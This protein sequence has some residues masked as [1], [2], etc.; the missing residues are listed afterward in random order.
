MVSTGSSSTVTTTVVLG[1]RK[2][3]QSED[4]LSIRLECASI[5]G[6]TYESQTECKTDTIQYASPSRS[7]A[8]PE[9]RYRCSYEGCSKAYTKPSRLAEHERVHT[10][11]VC[12]Y[13]CFLAY[14]KFLF[15]RP[16]T[17]S[18]CNKSYL[19]ETH[20]QAHTRSHLPVSARPFV[21]NE[22]DCGKRFWTSQH[23]RVHSELHR[24]E[25]PFK[26][27]IPCT[28]LFAYS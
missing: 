7:P 2:S 6:S 25:K 21:C 13:L 5:T 1:K 19:R 24:G 3:R 9:R 28:I 17:C 23:L 10:G 22:P 12:R 16:Y 4:K 27:R 26:V 20:L 11:D 8:I 14:V 18:T 15:Q